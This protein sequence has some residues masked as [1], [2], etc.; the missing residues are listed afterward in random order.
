[1]I[2]FADLLFIAGA[3][4]QSLSRTVWLMVVGRSIVGLAVGA[5]SFVTPLYIGELAPSRFRGRLVTLNVLFIT[6]GQVIAYV[7]ALFLVY[8]KPNGWRW[9]VGVGGIPAAIQ[10]VLMMAMPETPRWLVQAGR[11]GQAERVLRLV[12]GREAHYERTVRPVLQAIKA[13][14]RDEEEARRERSRSRPQSQNKA[15]GWAAE[16]LNS[17]RELFGVPAHRRALAISCMLQGLQQLCGFNSLM[18]FS[19]TL[20]KL[21]GF[22]NPAGASLAVAGTNLVGTVA[23]LALID[24][25]GR[26]RIL[27]WSVPIMALFLALC[28]LNFRGIDLP[29]IGEGD[30]GSKLMIRGQPIDRTNAILVLLYLTAY[31]GAYALGL[32]NVPWQQSELFPLSVRSLGSSIATATNWAANFVIGITFL[33]MLDGIGPMATFAIYAVIC[34]VGEFLIWLIYPETKGL[35]L[36]E[37]GELLKHGWGVEI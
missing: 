25:I 1:M 14:V 31:T 6:L 26:R 10:M 33:M 13:E 22:S 15:P 8:I 30:E 11:T 35:G 27:L 7:L 23:S 32:G 17:G 2:L 29:K 36:E 28:S 20:F 37:T 9:M 21:L 3:L 34:V 24:K 12:F 18:Y 4:I 5:A 16:V 19:A